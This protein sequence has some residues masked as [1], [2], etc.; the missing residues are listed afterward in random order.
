[1]ISDEN[2]LLGDSVTLEVLGPRS[3][4]DTVV[5]RRDTPFVY[6]RSRDGEVDELSQITEGSDVLL[7]FDHRG[8]TFVHEAQ[9]L[10]SNA[11][12]SPCELVLALKESRPRR[13]EQIRTA[14]RLTV[15]LPAELQ[16]LTEGEAKTCP[17][18]SAQVLDLSAGGARTRP[19]EPNL[20]LE[21]GEKLRLRFTLP[22]ATDSIEVLGEVVRR[23]PAQKHGEPDVVAL[24][25][26]SANHKSA[27]A[28]VQWV[29]IEQRRRA[30]TNTR[31]PN[32]APRP[33]QMGNL[34]RAR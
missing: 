12:Q 30:A 25:F 17:W 16:V 34:A 33:K 13:I 9:V 32:F 7:L 22:G 5:S 27:E 1:M 3:H 28:I 21:A 26:E 18:K 29:F 2:L 15:S 23:F 19:T 10:A 4:F 31:P 20:R 14:F 6:L 24:C 8:I 11:D